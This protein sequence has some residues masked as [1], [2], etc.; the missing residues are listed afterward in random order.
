MSCFD[1][2]RKGI[3]WQQRLRRRRCRGHAKTA[4]WVAVLRAIDDA[5]QTYI[6]ISCSYVTCLVSLLVY[7]HASQTDTKSDVRL[8]RLLSAPCPRNLLS[9]WGNSR[10]VLPVAQPVAQLVVQLVA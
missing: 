9:S 1:V 5:T 10:V 8:I 4:G 6:C 2:G 3:I 7:G